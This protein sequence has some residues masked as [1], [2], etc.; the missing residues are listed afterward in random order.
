MLNKQEFRQNYHKKTNI[1]K[2]YNNK[3]RHHPNL[4]R[5]DAFYESHHIID[6]FNGNKKIFGFAKDL[7]REQRFSI[8]TQIFSIYLIFMGILTIFII[9]IFYYVCFFVIILS[10]FLFIKHFCYFLFKKKRKLH[11]Y[12]FISN[13]FFNFVAIS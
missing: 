5:S 3:N 4:A 11:F 1:I 13:I 12:A 10:K 9:I 8:F 6:I 2:N 7:I